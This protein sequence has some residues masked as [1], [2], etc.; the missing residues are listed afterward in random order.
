MHISNV[1]I[2]FSLCLSAI[3]LEYRVV[4]LNSIWPLFINGAVMIYEG[5]KFKLAC[6]FEVYEEI[7][8]ALVYTDICLC[9]NNNKKAFWS[10]SNVYMNYKVLLQIS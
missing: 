3:P 1:I 9:K 10:P 4:E 5:L 6:T 8:P 7:R 2:R